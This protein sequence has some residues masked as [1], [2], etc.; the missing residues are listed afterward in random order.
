MRIRTDSGKPTLDFFN[1]KN[2]SKI[3]ESV[4]IGRQGLS[5][6]HTRRCIR[7]QK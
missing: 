7:M 5:K 4:K 6:H 2:K 3:R 1:K